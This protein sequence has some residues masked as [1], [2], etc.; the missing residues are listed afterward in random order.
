L[1]SGF[2]QV[3]F[4]TLQRVWKDHT[5]KKRPPAMFVADAPGLDFLNS[6]AKPDQRLEWLADGADLLAWLE[7]AGMLPPAT[8]SRMRAEA[9]PAELDQVA[10][11]ARQLREW[12]R[13]FVERHR[14]GMLAEDALAELG[15]LNALL[16]NDE[17]HRL[18]GVRKDNASEDVVSGLE[19][20]TVRRWRSAT[21]LLAPIADA[22]ADLVCS[23][24]FRQVKQCE[25]PTCTLLFHDATQGH[26]RRWCSMAVCGNRAKQAAYRARLKQQ[27]E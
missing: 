16:E 3:I 17:T 6:A 19:R 13:G 21:T 27:S 18:V 1:S 11:Q 8:A 15:P 24:D 5:M 10:A 20:V 2:Y 4:T 25:S 22:L 23:A 12:F 26:A 9:E 7:Q 14:G